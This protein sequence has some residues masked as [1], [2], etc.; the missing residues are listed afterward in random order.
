[1][2]KEELKQYIKDLTAQ[3]DSEQDPAKK[4]LMAQSL[5]K[6]VETYVGMITPQN[7]MMVNNE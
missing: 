2:N 1:M 4:E 3:M 6:A 5:Q 7:R